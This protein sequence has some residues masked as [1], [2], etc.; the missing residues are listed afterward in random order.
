M[1]MHVST[2]DK[3]GLGTGSSFSC[4]DRWERSMYMNKGTCVPEPGNDSPVLFYKE[5][6]RSVDSCMVAFQ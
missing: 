2:R 4:V 1:T 5:V 6:G 3:I